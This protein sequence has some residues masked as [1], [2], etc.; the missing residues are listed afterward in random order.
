M[1]AR[2]GRGNSRAM[3]AGAVLVIGAAV[4]IAPQV[5]GAQGP[6]TS[7]AIT[8]PTPPVGTRFAVTL[9]G[10][11]PVRTVVA[12]RIRAD[13]GSGCAPTYA[14][15]G[16]A[17]LAHVVVEGAFSL[18]VTATV[19]SRGTFLV[20]GWLG[21]TFGSTMPP[22]AVARTTF[23]NVPPV[24]RSPAPG[25]SAVR[26]TGRTVRA[27][28]GL[29]APGRVVVQLIGQG[30]RTTIAA[31][32]VSGPRRIAIAY[33]LPATGRAGVY[34]LRA[35][36]TATGSHRGAAVSRMVRFAEPVTSPPPR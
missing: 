31:R 12:A 10:W 21:L 34:T 28:V 13:D 35:G 15:D 23:G 17:H 20:C 14:A 6:T 7:L 9:S 32:T 27:G 29:R 36:F 22:L 33:T 30:R 2:H 1:R 18:P 24:V 4:A 26:V 25:L 3:G 19:H 16:G 5:A 11:S 8:P